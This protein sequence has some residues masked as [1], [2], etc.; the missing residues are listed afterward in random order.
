MNRRIK[1]PA[2]ALLLLQIFLFAATAWAQ[3]RKPAAGSGE[4]FFIIASIDQSKLQLLLKRPTEVT[5]LVKV[6]VKTQFLDEAGK[7]IHLSDLRAGDTVWAT[8]SGSRDKST[9]TRVRKG[10]MTMQQL[11]RYY[12]DYPEI[13]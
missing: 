4:D 13:K 5:E 2:V 12:L 6:A 7:P 11:H 9:T 1:S 8:V 10:P 3:G